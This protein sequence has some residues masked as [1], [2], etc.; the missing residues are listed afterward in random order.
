MY[1]LPFL[2]LGSTSLLS[3]GSP[4]HSPAREDL[5]FDFVIFIFFSLS[6]FEK[7]SYVAQPGLELDT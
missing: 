1:L 6:F 7:G 3:Q 4:R 2:P 5:G